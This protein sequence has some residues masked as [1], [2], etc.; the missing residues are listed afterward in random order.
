M[1]SP[2]AALNAL[3]EANFDDFSRALARGANRRTVLKGAVALFGS[4]LYNGFHSGK[5]LAQPIGCNDKIGACNSEADRRADRCFTNCLLRGPRQP[6]CAAGCR[7][8]LDKERA[9]CTR[10]GCRSTQTCCLNS[11]VEKT[12][13]LG[14]DP[15]NCG[16]CGHTCK[17]TECEVCSKGVCISTCGP[18]KEC[19]GGSCV[20]CKKLCHGICTD[21]STDR[22]NCGECDHFCNTGAIC[23]AGECKCPP[24]FETKRNPTGGSGIICIPVKCPACQSCKVFPPISSTAL[25]TW[26]CEMTGPVCRGCRPLNLDT[27]ACEEKCPTCL[28]CSGSEETGTCIPAGSTACPCGT[29]VDG[30]CRSCKDMGM[31]CVAGECKPIQCAPGALGTACILEKKGEDGREQPGVCCNGGCVPSVPDW[32]AFYGCHA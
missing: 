23:S 18:G 5:P 9:S 3:A 2:L 32:V 26:K 25:P 12:S 7:D 11:C 27:C 24:C 28:V 13:F 15:K 17:T 20:S 1:F 29:C 10:T 21:I 30:K 31:D 4:A 8:T 19:K 14:S 6:E 16:F 22:E